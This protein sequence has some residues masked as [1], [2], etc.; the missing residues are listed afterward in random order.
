M[1][2]WMNW[3]WLL[4]QLSNNS[5]YHQNN[6]LLFLMVLFYAGV[7]VH[8]LLTT[9]NCIDSRAKKIRSKQTENEIVI[10]GYWRA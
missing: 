4:L 8:H 7:V 6:S 1:D 5:T 9:G 2:G 3:S 10:P